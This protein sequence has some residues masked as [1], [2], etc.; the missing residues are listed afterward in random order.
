VAHPK[1]LS[2][3]DAVLLFLQSHP[4]QEFKSRELADGLQLTFPARFE[5]KAAQQIAAEIGAGGPQWLLKCSGLHRSE[6]A[7]RRYWW[8]DE[9]SP[10]S[11]DTPVVEPES[12]VQ[13]E[14]DLYPLLATFLISRHR[15]IY[16]KRIDEKKSSNSHGKEG[17]KWLHPDMVGLEEL[18]SGWSYEMKN[19]SAKSGARQCD[20]CGRPLHDEH[21]FAEVCLPT[22]AGAW[23]YAS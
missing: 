4:G 5:G 11:I 23:G 10:T 13:S 9:C 20:G 19:L 7:P 17:N 2:L 14:H 6:E 12:A 1:S 18:A 22:H 16:P 3:R 8:A 15:K 21:F